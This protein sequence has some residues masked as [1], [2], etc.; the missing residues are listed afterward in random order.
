MR[1]LSILGLICLFT[2]AS[3]ACENPHGYTSLGKPIP[4]G[5]PAPPPPPPPAAEM[6]FENTLW[7][8]CDG[9]HQTGKV[10]VVG[11]I[12]NIGNAAAVNIVLHVRLF[13]SE[14]NE[15]WY[16]THLYIDPRCDKSC[17]EPNWS[18]LG[19]EL[20]WDIPYEICIQADIETIRMNWVEVTWDNWDNTYCSTFDNQTKS[21]NLYGPASLTKSHSPPT[22][23]YTL[24]S[25]HVPDIFT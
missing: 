6:V 20:V 22:F 18:G 9:Y 15:I 1:K 17:I 4:P 23:R 24:H 21:L 5:P 16:E 11:E 14:D 13:D 19:V 2:F 3:M 7:C 25:S 10:S 12:D 8:E